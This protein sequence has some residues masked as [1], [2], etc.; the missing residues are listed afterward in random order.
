MPRMFDGILFVFEKLRRCCR[1][2]SGRGFFDD[3]AGSLNDHFGDDHFVTVLGIVDGN[4]H[5][6]TDDFDSDRV[7]CLVDDRCTG[8]VRISGGSRFLAGENQGTRGWIECGD[9]A[10]GW[11]CCGDSFADCLRPT[12]TR[13]S[14]DCGKDEMVLFHDIIESFR[15]D[16]MDGLMAASGGGCGANS[17]SQGS[18]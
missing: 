10:D 4:R 17:R 9:G 12:D 6:T 11:R 5:A 7:T 18:A 16:S 1:C 13:Q 15:S 2:C 8:F 3:R 14:N